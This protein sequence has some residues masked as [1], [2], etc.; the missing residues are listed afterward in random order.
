MSAFIVAPKCINSIV[1]YLNSHVWS[2]RWL[3]RDLGFNV[4]EGDD[5]RRLAEAFYRL[6][7]AAVDQRYGNG[8]AAKDKSKAPAFE[9]WMTIRRPVEV[10]KAAC[11]LRYQCSEGSVPEQPLFQALDYIIA[12]IAD[13]IIK[14]L[15]EYDKA[16][17]GD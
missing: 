15:P 10:Y 8:T 16:P 13:K 9:F 12:A 2:F 5:L 11:C 7:C 1:T 3:E 14:G 4:A 17:W 6:N